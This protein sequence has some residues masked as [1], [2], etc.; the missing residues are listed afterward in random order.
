[1]FGNA[2][3]GHV[4]KGGCGSG[5]IALSKRQYRPTVTVRSNLE[6]IA[7]PMNLK[8]KRLSNALLVPWYSDGFPLSI[9]TKKEQKSHVWCHNDVKIA[10]LEWITG[11]SWILHQKCSKKIGISPCFLLIKDGNDVSIIYLK[12]QDHTMKWFQILP[13]CIHPLIVHPLTLTA[14]PTPTPG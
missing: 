12:I 9:H 5:A 4:D 3:L 14:Y 6:G 1:M 13:C 10:D 8:N 11:Q 2:P 7:T